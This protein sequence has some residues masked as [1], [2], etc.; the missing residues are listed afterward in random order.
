MWVAVVHKEG[1]RTWF[2]LKRRSTF[3]TA[4]SKPDVDGDKWGESNGKES[5]EHGAQL[6]R[7]SDYGCGGQE[8]GEHRGSFRGWWWRDKVKCPGHEDVVPD[9]DVEGAASP[10]YACLLAAS[11]KASRVMPNSSNG[12]DCR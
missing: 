10:E 1:G 12:R 2:R 6:G 3:R 8:A 7:G 5:N 11:S 4:S 9:G